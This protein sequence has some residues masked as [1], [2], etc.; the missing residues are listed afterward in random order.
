MGQ[1]QQENIWKGVGSPASYGFVNHAA[2]YSVFCKAC[3]F[4][5][6]RTICLEE[7]VWQSGNSHSFS[8]T[9]P[10]ACWK[11]RPFS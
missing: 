3:E 9:L 5:C 4:L 10:F 6:L 7:E 11:L 2:C 8:D 1:G